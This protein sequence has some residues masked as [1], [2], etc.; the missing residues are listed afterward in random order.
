MEECKNSE[1]CRRTVE[2]GPLLQDTRNP[3]CEGLEVTQLEIHLCGQAYEE[4]PAE[5]LDWGDTR[6]CRPEYDRQT[7]RRPEYSL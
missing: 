3:F 5:P 7:M 6:N 2:G 4:H 1:F